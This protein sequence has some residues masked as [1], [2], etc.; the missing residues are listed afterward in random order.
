MR[1]VLYIQR[2]SD[3]ATKVNVY[4]GEIGMGSLKE[5]GVRSPKLIERLR[6]YAKK[7][8]EGGL[9]APIDRFDPSLE[10]WIINEEE[11]AEQ[12]S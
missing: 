7:H 6:R 8:G 11:E 4:T 9:V 1:K 10:A 5:Y 3:G 2:L 12:E